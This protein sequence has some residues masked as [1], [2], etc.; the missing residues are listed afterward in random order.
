MLKSHFDAIENSLVAISRIPANSG[1]PLHMG[2]PR[3]SFIREFLENHLAEN[4]SIGTGEII[5]SNSLPGQQRNQYDIV[6]YRNNYPKLS[7]G[8]G[9]N[10]FLIE[11]VIATIEV[12]STLTND[13]LEN[14]IKAAR[15]SKYLTKNGV[16]TYF[17]GFLPPSIL[18]YVIAYDG[19][20]NIST[21]YGWLPQI[22]TNLG[23][24]VNNLPADNTA[25]IN[26]PSPSVDG[27]FIL[28]KGFIYYDNVSLGF[29]N[30]TTRAAADPNVK[31]VMADTASGNLLLLFLFLLNANA[32]IHSQSFNA[33]SYL[34]SFALP[35]GCLNLGT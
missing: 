22:H 12:K 27:I 26:T 31:W 14:A 21:V 33:S 2:T 35:P 23:I 17:T 5:D 6:I 34:R 11:S 20:A 15:N 30:P 13:E 28:K 8:G 29:L 9:I 19:P 32:N 7:F 25:R 1:H 4:V 16:T 10:G 18:N 24:T 3:E